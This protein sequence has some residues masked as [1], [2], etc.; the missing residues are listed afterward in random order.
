LNLF[1]RALEGNPTDSDLLS[2]AGFA[3]LAHGSPQEAVD[4][5]QRA[6]AVSPAPNTLAAL[7]EAWLRLGQP[8]RAVEVLRR[9]TSL[10]GATTWAWAV[11]AE[12][13]I[14]TGELTAAE[15]AILEARRPDALTPEDR[16]A[17]SRA[18][19][20]LANWSDALTAL[21]PIL[22]TGEVQ[23]ELKL[24][25][26]ILRVLEA[27]WVFADAALA[28]RH[29]PGP[30]VPSESL[31]AWVETFLAGADESSGRLMSLGLRL[32]LA[33][34]FDDDE[35][36]AGLRKLVSQEA[37]D[38]ATS[39]AL[40]IALLRRQRPSEALEVLRLVH[41]SHLGSCWQALLA[42]IAH[43]QGGNPSLARQALVDASDDAGLF[44][45]AQAM[46]ARAHLAQGYSDSAVTALNAALSRWPD[47][48]AWHEALADLYLATADYDAALP[49]LQ[50]AVEFEPE[51]AT[52]RLTYARAL[53]GA[54]HLSDALAEFERVLP[55][56]PAE[57]QV[58]HEAGDLALLAGAAAQAEARFDRAASLDPENPIHL[59][60][61]A[62]AA[63]AGARL[64]DARRSAE[65]AIRLGGERSDALQCLA[66]V[67]AKQGETERAIELLNRAQAVAHDETGLRRVRTRLLIELDRAGQAALELRE[68]LAGNPE[69]DEA[70]PS[71]ADA[72]EATGD[73][74][75]AGQAL[76][77][78]LRLRPRSADLHVQLA[79]IERKSGQLDRALDLLRQ[80]ETIDPL[81]GDL[82]LEFGQV[83]EARRELDHALDAY[84]RA[85]EVNPRAPDAFRR[86]GHVFKS[87]KAYAEAEAMLQRAAD[88]DPTDTATL[89]QLAAVRALELV[90]G[91]TYRMAVNP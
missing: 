30:D 76:E 4:L 23:H 57:A 86:A 61:K 41:P 55:L 69:D 25:E 20:R 65:N 85:T 62:Q 13:A 43:L 1:A 47:E 9:A 84:C 21:A 38:D 29:A 56:M 73:Y 34:V 63:L 45:F 15:E 26:M 67:A 54:G 14:S 10:P 48:P 87:L 8:E 17:L 22:S 40:A 46:L 51:H 50:S 52:W 42:G 2:E 28:R 59:V 72:L 68:H 11:T 36:L 24:A 58:W 60:G 89:Q 33:R 53:R 19:L 70:W 90:H 31:M 77:A 6:A 82:A 91:G 83:Y 18:E 49:H 5:L 66:E 44:P 71:L 81:Q 35:A 7:G 75:A 32:R 74:P 27:R 88:L 78:A 12:A 64:R 37:A 80:A 39:E 3:T 79:R 16:I